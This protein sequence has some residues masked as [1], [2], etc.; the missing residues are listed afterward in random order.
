LDAAT[1]D[2]VVDSRVTIASPSHLVGEVDPT[3]ESSAKHG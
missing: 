1:G 3:P 2:F